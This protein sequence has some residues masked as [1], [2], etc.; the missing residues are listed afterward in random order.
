MISIDVATAMTTPVETVTVDATMVE[1]ARRLRDAHIGALVVLDDDGEI[2][3]VVTESNII[4]VLTGGRDLETATVADC[5]V[6]PVVT[7]DQDETV[8]AAG[9]RMCE[10]SVR[11]MPV[12]ADGDLVGIVTTTD[13]AYYL[14]RLRTKIRRARN[15]STSP[16]GGVE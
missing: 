10:H 16:G 12:L 6:S 2:V 9:E 4:T 11:R 14:P 1:A 13:L 7:I 15:T 3:G 8:V 5:L